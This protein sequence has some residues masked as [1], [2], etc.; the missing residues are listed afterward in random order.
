MLSLWINIFPHASA[1]DFSQTLKA[2]EQGDADAQYNLGWMYRKGKGVDKDY[3][4]AAYWYT[5]AVE[6]GDKDAQAAL[7]KLQK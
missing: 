5:Q 1:S 4:K 2:A 7:K 6:Q 3:A